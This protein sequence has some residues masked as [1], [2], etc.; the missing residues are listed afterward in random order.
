M[1]NKWGSW[2]NRGAGDKMGTKLEFTLRNGLYLEIGLIFKLFKKCTDSHV[3][4]IYL[5]KMVLF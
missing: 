1:E 2:D 5:R 3:D 4:R